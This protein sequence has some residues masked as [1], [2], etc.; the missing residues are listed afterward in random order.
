[1]LDMLD[2]RPELP[3]EAGTIDGHEF[4]PDDKWLAQ[5]SREMQI[6]AMRQWFY[7]RYQ[8]PANDTPYNGKE[9]GYLFIHG[10]PYDPDDVIQERFSDIVEFE[11]I[12]E[13]VHELYGEVGDEWAPIDHDYDESDYDS[14]LSMLGNIEQSPYQMLLEKLGQI[15]DVLTAHGSPHIQ[16]LVTQLAHGAAITALEAYLLEVTTKKVLEDEKNL[17]AFV[18]NNTDPKFGKATLTLSTIFKRMDGIKD[19]VNAYLQTFIWHR[20]DRVKPILEMT[21]GITVPDIAELMAEVVIRHDIVHRGGK[22]KKGEPVTVTI[23]GVNRVVDLIQ[24]FCK[25]IEDELDKRFP[26]DF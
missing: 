1:M 24:A 6:E 12:Q 18:D 4:N 20:L 10:G 3:D 9:G 17:R 13:L 7:S 14:Y 5:A 16:A 26:T 11:H 22:N 2:D 21:F 19:E 23:V 25:S 8:D 15:K